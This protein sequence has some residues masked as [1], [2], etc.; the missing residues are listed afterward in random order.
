MDW[1]T[2]LM[3]SMPTVELI[4]RGAITFLALMVLLRI[5]GQRESGGI[6][7]TDLLVVVLVANAAGA[8]MMAGAQSVGDG[9]VVAATML[10]CSVG[11]DAAAYRWPRLARLVK[12][13]PRPLITDGQFNRRALRR[14]FMTEQ[15]VLSQLRL[16]G[17]SDAD[18]VARAYL[19]PNGM[20]SII[21]RSGAG[22]VEPPEG[23]R[24]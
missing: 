22:T 10:F 19:E 23:P 3:P 7:L 24:V 14:E 12:S 1:T 9:L 4:A 17:I 2:T 21:P 15:E 18:E 16:H 13:R 6:G 8:G 20:I 11:I 5:I